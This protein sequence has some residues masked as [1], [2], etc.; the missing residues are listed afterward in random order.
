MSI[1]VW[2]HDERVTYDY[3]TISSHLSSHNK[4]KQR[5]SS[6]SIMDWEVQFHPRY[7]IYRHH[8]FAV[9]SRLLH[10]VVFMP[11]GFLVDTPWATRATCRRHVILRI[12][13]GVIRRLWI[14]SYRRVAR[15]RRCRFAGLCQL[16]KGIFMPWDK[17]F[18]VSKTL[19][20]ANGKRKKLN[21][22]RVYSFIFAVC[23][24]P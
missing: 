20:L 9:F 11:R 15:W 13:P 7:N 12:H 16:S 3:T 18:T 17:V 24:L 4:T 1:N 10:R 22:C 19:G 5:T 8:P 23:R 21:F 14:S 6:W 2:L